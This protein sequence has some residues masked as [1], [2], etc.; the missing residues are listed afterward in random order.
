[1]MVSLLSQHF[2]SA[3]LQGGVNLRRRSNM[4]NICKLIQWKATT[5][6]INVDPEALM[7]PTV[8]LMCR[9]DGGK[10]AVNTLLRFLAD[11]QL[12]TN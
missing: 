10:K 9:S 4:L 7:G 2:L 8:A 3:V 11:Y 12:R 5:V 6:T 1:M